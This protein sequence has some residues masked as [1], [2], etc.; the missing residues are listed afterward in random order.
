MTPERVRFGSDLGGRPAFWLEDVLLNNA[1]LL[2]QAQGV[3]VRVGLHDFVVLK[4]VDGDPRDVAVLAARSDAEQVAFVSAAARPTGDHRVPVADCILNGYAEIREGCPDLL[5]VLLEAL[6]T[7]R[8][9]EVRVVGD[10]VGGSQ[11]VDLV[12]VAIVPNLLSKLPHERLII[13]SHK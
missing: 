9:R 13:R 1:D 7:I 11:L 4:A 12:H 3:K 2:Q 8:D 10:E 6:R 5:D